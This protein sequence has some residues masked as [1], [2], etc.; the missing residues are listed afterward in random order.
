MSTKKNLSEDFVKQEFLN[1]IP[2]L[3]RWGAQV[4]KVLNVFVT[5]CFNAVEHVQFKA[6]HRVKGLE[7]YCTKVLKRKDYES[8]L[9]ETTD[10]VG[11]R[12]V[13]LDSKDV[14]VVSNYVMETNEWEICEQSRDTEQ[15]ILSQPDVFTY[16]SNH[17]IV[18]PNKSY[19]TCVDK[20]LL[21]CEIQIRTIL[22]HAYAEISHDTVYKKTTIRNSKAKRMLA[23][24]MAFL[25]AAD[26]KFLQIYDAMENSS[27][28]FSSFQDKLISLYKACDGTYDSNNF[29]VALANQILIMYDDEQLNQIFEKLEEF[30]TNP[31]NGIQKI[32]FCF[33]EKNILFKHPIVLV[34]LYGIVNFQ[35][36]TIRN[37]SLNYESLITIIK[38][39]G[40]STNILD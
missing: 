34:T 4:D 26:E 36:H 18:K 21:T 12:V 40:F 28:M 29:D 2:E 13:V 7:S 31:T 25:E 6:N 20:N 8:P 33:K 3:E 5:T 17:F 19:Q 27:D 16:Q 24:S 38:A 32:I 23:S 15:E 9:L 37:W 14:E 1:L 35:T 11:T 22:Q 30:C 39:M 10:K